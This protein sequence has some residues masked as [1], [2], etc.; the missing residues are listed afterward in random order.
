MGD[1]LENLSGRWLSKKTIDD[2]RTITQT[3]EIKKD[4]LTFEIKN[5][6]GKAILY[7]EGNIK[8][9]TLGSFKTMK[10]FDIKAGESAAETESVDG[11]RTSIYQF[12]GGTWTLASNFDAVRDEKPSVDVYTKEGK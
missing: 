12:S 10:V 7:A 2:G 4:K 8:L 5:K 9:E 3:I 1:D 6:D 11:N